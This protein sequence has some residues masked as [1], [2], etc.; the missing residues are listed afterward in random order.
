[1]SIIKRIFFAI[2][3]V[4]VLAV[5]TYLGAY[6]SILMKD[7]KTENIVLYK[8]EGYRQVLFVSITSPSQWDRLRLFRIHYTCSAVIHIHAKAALSEVQEESIELEPLLGKN[9]RGI[10]KNPDGII[11]IIQ[12]GPETLNRKTLNREDD[13]VK[14][15]G[16]YEEMEKLLKDFKEG[17]YLDFSKVGIP[18]AEPKKNL[19][20]QRKSRICV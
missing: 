5:L 13:F 20:K 2:L 8:D 16:L 12:I 9:I 19:Q 14:Y 17:N 4:L 15:K 6:I 3:L 11:D 18:E 7:S 1:M 10:I